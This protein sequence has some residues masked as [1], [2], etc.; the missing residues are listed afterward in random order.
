MADLLTV[1]LVVCP[2]VFIAGFVDSVAGGGGIISLPAYFMVGIPPHMAM[3]TNKFVATL[4]TSLAAFEYIVVGKINYKIAIISSAG[5]VIGS[6]I[7]TQIALLMSPNLLKYIILLVLPAVAIFLTVNKNFGADSKKFDKF[8]TK[9]AMVISLLIGLTIGCYDGIIGPGTGTFLILA[10]SGIL[11][12]DLLTSSGCAKLSNLASNLTSMIIFLINGKVLFAVAIP[13]TVFG[14]LGNFFGSRY[15]IR[16]GSKNIRKIMFVVLGLLFLK[17][18]Y[19][20][21]G[22]QDVL[23]VWR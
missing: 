14:L 15:A 7:G 4:G 16:G 9:A 17:L 23:A 13:A 20:L 22:A 5:A 10:F 3:G 6:F 8:S 12:I 19:D 11:G 18:G 21:I 2:L 1:L